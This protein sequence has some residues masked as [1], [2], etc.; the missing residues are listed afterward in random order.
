[1]S[2]DETNVKLEVQHTIQSA[3]LYDTSTCSSCS[4]SGLRA[5]LWPWTR[6]TKLVNLGKG[7]LF[8]REE[9]KQ[10]DFT[11]TTNKRT[12]QTHPGYANVAKENQISNLGCLAS[13]P[14][15]YIIMASPACT[16]PASHPQSRCNYE[17]RFWTKKCDQG[18]LHDLQRP[19]GTRSTYRHFPRQS[20]SS[21]RSSKFC[22]CH[23]VR[24]HHTFHNR[25][26][27][28]PNPSDALTQSWPY[29]IFQPLLFCRIRG[30]WRQCSLHRQPRRRQTQPTYL[31]SN[32]TSS[33]RS[34]GLSAKHDPIFSFRL[35]ARP[36]RHGGEQ[37][38][39][40]QQRRSPES[41]SIHQQTYI[42]LRC[43]PLHH[44]RHCP[45]PIVAGP[46]P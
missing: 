30:G 46:D 15:Q 29:T 37:A 16:S 34:H 14:P 5:A 4:N 38:A 42:R 27:P 23:H 17:L 21:T 6:A 8:G 3:C 43:S 25:T 24:R 13:A 39:G 2:N 1:M 26:T 44:T 36:A 33:L 22:S 32:P 12:H 9:G 11:M 35:T 18:W 28:S 10:T 7:R 40:H 20:L 31:L 41:V 45:A 19:T